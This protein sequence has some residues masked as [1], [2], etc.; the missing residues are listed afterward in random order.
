M[1]ALCQCTRP[2]STCGLCR[3]EE[4]NIAFNEEKQREMFDDVDGMDNEETNPQK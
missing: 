2:N 3:T 1:E 4:E